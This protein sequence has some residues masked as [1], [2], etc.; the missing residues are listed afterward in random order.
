MALPQSSIKELL[1]FLKK[2]VLSDVMGMVILAVPLN[3]AAFP[4]APPLIAMSLAV[5]SFAAVL[6][7]A[8][9]P[10]QLPEEPDTLPVTLPVKLP[11]MLVAVTFVPLK[12]V[13]TSCPAVVSR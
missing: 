12:V 7:E 10:V 5:V 9:L 11:L 3:A 1:P 2:S 6:A 13:A 4:T 8:A